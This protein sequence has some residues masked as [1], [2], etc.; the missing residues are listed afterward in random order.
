MTSTIALD[1]EFVPFRKIPRLLRDCIITEKIDGT[2][3]VI[4]ISEDGPD[5]HAGSRTRW[6]NVAHDNYGFAAW[7]QAHL[8]E[9]LTLGPGY[10]F[11]EWWGKGIQRKYGLQEKRFSLFNVSK[12]CRHDETPEPGQM[13][14]PPCVGKVPV[15]YHGPFSTQA[16]KDALDRLI[17][18]GSIAAPGFMQP[19]GIVVYHLASGQNFKVTIGNDG[20]KGVEDGRA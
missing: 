11:G 19:E 20:N 18:G 4:H 1:P 10:H 6:V 16:V 17:A 13:V 9:L 2:N 15:L 3:G 5:L 8:A 7:C 12:Y 14:L